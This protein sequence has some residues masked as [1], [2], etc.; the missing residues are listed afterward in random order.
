MMI[1]RSVLTS[2]TKKKKE[3][4]KKEHQDRCTSIS[5][6]IIDIDIEDIRIFQRLKNLK[7][8]VL[9]EFP[10][11]PSQVIGGETAFDVAE[12]GNPPPQDLSSALS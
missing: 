9:I 3:R 6:Y 5:I 4:R 7:V 1:D 8:E 12:S 10:K 2:P 11:A